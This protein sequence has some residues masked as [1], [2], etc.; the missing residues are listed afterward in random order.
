MNAAT[1]TDDFTSSFNCSITL[2]IAYEPVT[3]VCGHLFDRPSIVNWLRSN[4]LCPVCR[5]YISDSDLTINRP[6]A[7]FIEAMGYS[8]PILPPIPV[9]PELL[10]DDD[11]VP[12]LIT[13]PV[14]GN[15]NVTPNGQIFEFRPPFVA[16]TSTDTIVLRAEDLFGDALVA[17]GRGRLVLY[18]PHASIN[19]FSRNRA[20]LMEAHNNSNFAIIVQLGY[21][22]G[23]NHYLSIRRY[24]TYAQTLAAASSALTAAGIFVYDLFHIRGDL[25]SFL[26]ISVDQSGQPH[27]AVFFER[28]RPLFNNNNN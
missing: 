28:G 6:V 9:V 27:N 15:F 23:H 22:F 4:D 13:L 18:H 21:R 3:T 12:E 25:Y 20:L 14:Q 8:R 2:D 5:R 26:S 10:L 17:L 24:C 7:Q 19:P 16:V 1:Q 11:D